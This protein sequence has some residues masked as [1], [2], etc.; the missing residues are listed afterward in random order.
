MTSP[1]SSTL[2][3]NYPRTINSTGGDV[4]IELI[5]PMAV[6]KSTVAPLVAERLGIAHYQGQAFHGLNN[7]PLSAGEQWV[8]RLWSV[9][10]NP[11]LFVSVLSARGGSQ[12]HRLS[13]ALNMCRRDRFAALAASSASG[14]I[15]SGP[16]HALCQEAA[17]QHRWGE[18]NIASFA[19]HIVPAD[20]YVR[21]SADP[22][23]VTRRLST[24]EYF[25]RE[26]VAAHGDWIDRYDDMVNEML[27][28]LDRPVIEVDADAGPEAVADEVTSRLTT[29]IDTGN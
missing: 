23:E 26:Y 11:M 22:V 20:C 9:L 15:E 2:W 5:G 19:A 13:F 27:A 3:A 7:K 16:V 12:K 1:D 25:P 18:R 24:R 14:L 29:L 17:W 6:G 4:I 10:R 28:E 8:D 21:L